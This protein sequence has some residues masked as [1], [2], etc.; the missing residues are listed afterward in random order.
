MKNRVDKL[1]KNVTNIIIIRFHALICSLLCY[2]F[3]TIAY[4]GHSSSGNKEI[5]TPDEHLWLIKNQSRIV[6]AVETG[7]A[8][9]VFIDSNDQP[10][11]LANDY[12]LLIE[13]KLGVHFNQR[14]FSSLDDIFEKVRSGEVHIVNAV[15]KTPARSKFLSMT[16]PF[17]SV[18]NVIVVK[19]DRLDLHEGNLFGLKVSLVK[20]Y[21]ITENLAN[22]NI[23]FSPDLVPDD[24]TALLNVSFG[25]SDAA[26][27]DLATASY[28]IE[29]NGITN[30]R[31]AGQV[32]FKIQLSMATPIGEPVLYNI[33]QKGLNAITVEERQHIHKR[34]INAS[35]ER[36]LT[37]RQLWVVMGSALSLVLMVFIWNRSLRQ[38]VTLR[39]AA[40]VKGQ[41]S[42][43]ESE[44]Q[45]LA[46]IT[47]HNQELE[48]Q[49]AER[50]VELT[51]VSRKLQQ[52]SELD[53]L[54]GI[55]NRRKFDITM[56][57]E[58]RRAIREEYPITL[59]MVDIDHFKEY[60]DQY[61][62]QAGDV[63]I[64][65]V[66]KI[67]NSLTQRAG[68]LVA[69]YGGEEFAIILPGQDK[70]TASKVAEKIR[71]AIE[72]KYIPHPKNTPLPIVTIS[73]G[74]ASC[75]PDQDTQHSMLLQLADACLYRAKN[76][77]RNRVVTA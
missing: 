49:I 43:K 17:I 22:K 15:T 9:F 45:K 61:G 19:K 27:I 47:R 20:N 34:W 67:L 52:L 54:T 38:Q 1:L 57:M 46:L 6:L 74:V 68:E 12:I 28:L 77:G 7:Y 31:V 37:N 55:A 23:G 3:I 66:A 58:W 41:E 13:S 14:R 39:T 4:A 56:D 71:H 32:A 75:V 30:L 53:E 11:G 59:L 21:A 44:A 8:P 63:C 18:P 69:R 36:L 60:N 70:S 64:Q 16:D 26:A 65:L 35:S 25:R 10:T 40:L 5:L 42:L 24:L 72:S 50:T 73:I 62:H 76:E 2:F 29:H 51:E 33:L 48:R